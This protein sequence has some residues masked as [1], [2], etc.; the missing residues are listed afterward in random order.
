MAVLFLDFS[1][2]NL[3]SRERMNTSAASEGA[4]DVGYGIIRLMTKKLTRG[5]GNGKCRPNPRVETKKREKG[6]KGFARYYP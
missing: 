3:Q 6:S 1:T 5:K 4:G 2:L